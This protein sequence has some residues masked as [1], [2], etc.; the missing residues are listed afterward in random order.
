MASPSCHWIYFPDADC[1]FQR[2]TEFGNFSPAMAPAGMCGICL[3]IPCDYGD[4]IWR[5]DPGALFARAMDDARRQNF[6]DPAWVRG[7]QVVRERFAYPMFDLGS[8]EKLRRIKEYLALF[9][10]LQSIGRQGDFRY[11]NIDDALLAGFAAADRLRST[12]ARMTRGGAA[13]TG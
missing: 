12:G 13:L 7:Y 1:L 9:P 3:E 8:E 2:S 6:L 10:R 4:E 5:M 11:I